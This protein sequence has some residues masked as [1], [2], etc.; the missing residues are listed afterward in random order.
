MDE[1]NLVIGPTRD[2]EF[3]SWISEHRD[4][5]VINIPTAGSDIMLWRRAECG[6]FYPLGVTHAVEG[7]SVKA[8]SLNPG[9]LAAWA[10]ARGG[11]LHYCQT[12]CEKWLSEQRRTK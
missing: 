8:Y 2:A 1:S 12:C 6:H 10:V 5:H 9:A 11:N 3:E 7:R 4:G